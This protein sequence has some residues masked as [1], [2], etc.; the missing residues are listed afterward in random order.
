[1]AEVSNVVRFPERPARTEGRRIYRAIAA[2]PEAGLQV[3]DYL[4]IKPDRRPI[5]LIRILPAALLSITT[6]PRLVRVDGGA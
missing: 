6:D 3:G 5:L 1:M 4:H 2:V